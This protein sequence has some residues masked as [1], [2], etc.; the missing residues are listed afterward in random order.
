MISEEAVER[1]EKQKTDEWDWIKVLNREELLQEIELTIEKPFSEL[2][3]KTDPF[4]HQLACFLIGIFNKSFFFMLDLGTG[5]TKIILDLCTYYRQNGL[6]K[7]ILVLTPTTTAVNTWV[8]QS[9]EH[10]DLKCISLGDRE[11]RYEKIFDEGDIYA[12]NYQGLYGFVCERI[13]K[14]KKKKSGYSIVSE[15]LIKFASLFDLVCFDE[16]HDYLRNQSSLTYKICETLVSM[17]KFTYL[18]TGTPANRDYHDIW[19]QNKLV[20]GGY[21]LGRTLT[22]FRQAFYDSYEV[23]FRGREHPPVLQYKIVKGKSEVIARKLKHRSIL[24]E[25]DEVS[26]LPVKHVI[27]QDFRFSREMS[28]CYKSVIDDMKE[29]RYDFN[30]FKNEYMKLKRIC[31]GYS[32]SKNIDGEEIFVHFDYN[33]KMNGLIDIILSLPGR[34]KLIVFCWFVESGRMILENIRKL[35]IGNP[36]WLHGDVKSKE[37]D[38]IIEKF[39]TDPK[40][41]IMIAN[42]KSGGTSLNLQVANYAVFFENHSYIGRR[43]GE[44][45]IHREGQKKRTFIYD[46]YIKGSVE[47]TVLKYIDEG[48][49]L[50]ESLKKKRDFSEIF[51]KKDLTENV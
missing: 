39:Q 25:E 50:L 3:I 51:E 7:K 46:F 48:K 44:K 45:R 41:R 38:S 36:V 5:K 4:T 27:K 43:Q 1:F 17:S 11:D 47:E 33:P 34:S 35:K 2:G 8:T 10:S 13:K 29:A 32:P 49:D 40:T 12:M 28:E 18:L 26:D 21:S 23:Y 19:A 22:L 9:R 6:K 15:R 14:G 31:S 16:S 42:I 20:D 24:Y 30:H 37:K